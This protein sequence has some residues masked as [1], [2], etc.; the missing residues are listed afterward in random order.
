[1]CLLTVENKPRQPHTEAR[2]RQQCRGEL[3]QY[4]TAASR[5]KDYITAPAL[6]S[7]LSVLVCVSFSVAAVCSIC[8][9]AVHS[10]HYN[11]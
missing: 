7:I 9:L 10:C 11:W 8:T 5:T 1:V 3:R 2:P 4:S 6:A